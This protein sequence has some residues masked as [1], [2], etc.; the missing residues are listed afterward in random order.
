LGSLFAGDERRA[1]VEL[2][3]SLE[4]GD[5]RAIDA[6][7]SWS[8][9][10]GATADVTIPRLDVTAVASDDEVDRARDGA[11][12]ASAT[13]AFASQREVEAAEAYA[14]GD[15]VRAQALIDQNIAALG[16]AASAAPAPA[17]ASLAKQSAEYKLH[18][19][20]FAATAPGSDEGKR[21][22]KS[23]AAKDMS[24]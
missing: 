19:S 7:A 17:A 24:N 3:S 14:H 2:T 11:V 4:T 23:A 10:G 16:A 13:S 22:A 21:A 20:S 8:R 18:K 1:I 9:V 15:S 12:F 5:V 6:Q